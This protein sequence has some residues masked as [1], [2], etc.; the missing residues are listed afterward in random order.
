MSIIER[1]LDKQRQDAG[2]AGRPA[3]RTPP[4]RLHEPAVPLPAPLRERRTPSEAIEVDLEALR[5]AGMLPLAE[6]SER[7]TEQF[8]RIK[9]PLLEAVIGRSAESAP[10]GNALM[11][12]SAVAGEGKS[13]VCFN[14]AL[15]IARERDLDVLLVDADV[16]KRHLTRLLGADARRGLTDAAA[17]ANVDPEQLVLGT[18]VSGLAFLPAGKRSGI[19]SELFASR[20]MADVVEGLCRADPRRIVLFDCSPLLATHEAQVLASLANQI[21]LVVRAEST[22]QHLVLEAINLL[23]RTKQIRCVLNQARASHLSEYY[24]YG[25]GYPANEQPRAP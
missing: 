12:A 24:Y 19:V 6:V 4:G 5:A 1:A 17:D 21:V 9:W 10:A 23:D 13:F 15:S 22:E 25:Y 11:V 7:I 3:Q 16:A 2:E 20:R 18:N 14:L 8:R